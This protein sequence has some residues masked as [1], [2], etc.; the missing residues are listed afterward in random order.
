MDAQLKK[1]RERDRKAEWRAKQ[2]AIREGTFKPSPVEQAKTFL[3]SMEEPEVKAAFDDPDLGPSL[4][5]EDRRVLTNFVYHLKAR[6][7]KDGE[8]EL[9]RTEQE[10][11]I[12]DKGRI[13]VN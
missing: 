12:S 7:R 10:R 11:L 13:F 2:H 9:K 1:D 5:Q 4:R 8:E 3:E 6:R